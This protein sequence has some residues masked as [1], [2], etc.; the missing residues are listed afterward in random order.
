MKS[1]LRVAARTLALDLAMGEV[2]RGLADAVIDCMI[3]KGL[4]M[5]R[6]LYGDVPGCRNYGDIDLL[7]ARPAAPARAGHT[8][9]ARAEAVAA[10]TWWTLR[11]WWRVHQ[12]LAR[13]PWAAAALP[14]TIAPTGSAPPH[15]G[16][17]ARL[18]LACCRASCLETALVR[19]AHAAG[20]GV[21]IDVIVGVTAPATGFRSHAWLDGDRVDPEFVELCRFPAVTQRPG[22]LR[23]GA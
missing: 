5:A 3:L 22:L 20:A 13:G 6:R 16:R 21:A 1:D 4:A 19:Q 12:R 8:H 11:T 15:S 9:R 7:V 23:R 2:V 10:T 14:A 18:V 17:A